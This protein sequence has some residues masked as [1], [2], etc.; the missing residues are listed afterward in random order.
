MPHHSYYP[1]DLGLSVLASWRTNKVPIADL[2]QVAGWASYRVYPS[3]ITMRSKCEPGYA[4]YE[5]LITEL[6]G[7]EGGTEGTKSFTFNNHYY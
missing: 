6:S 7:R 5:E 2:L 1:E 3:I 4:D